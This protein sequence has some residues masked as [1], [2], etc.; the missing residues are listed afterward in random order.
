MKNASSFVIPLSNSGQSKSTF[1]AI[2]STSGRDIRE[3]DTVLLEPDSLAEHK[4][5]SLFYAIKCLI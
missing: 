2:L 4:K 1:V 5:K 3:R